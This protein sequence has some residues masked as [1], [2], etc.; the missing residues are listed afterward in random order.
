MRLMAWS[1]S[2]LPFHLLELKFYFSTP[3]AKQYNNNEGKN[4]NK[5]KNTT[6]LLYFSIAS[7]ENQQVVSSSSHDPVGWILPHEKVW[8]KCQNSAN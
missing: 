7:L 8:K 2:S 6:S 4:K 1:S 3:I 5:N